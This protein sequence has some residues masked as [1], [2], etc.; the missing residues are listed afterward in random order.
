MDFSGE[1]AP[2]SRRRFLVTGIKAATGVFGLLLGIPLISFFISP[3]LK[4]EEGEWIAIGDYSQLKSGEPSKITYKHARK[5]GWAVAETRKTVFVLKQPGGAVTVWSNKCTHL[6]CAVDW[7]TSSNQFK[8][9]CHGAVFDIQGNVVEG[10][11]S[12]PLNKLLAKVEDN[13]VFIKEA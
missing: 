10:P 5:D 13:K 3:V 7:S 12:K 11:P 1:G 9:P 8:C 2:P 6:G 4:K